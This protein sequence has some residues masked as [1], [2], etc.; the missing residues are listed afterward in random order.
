MTSVIG[1]LLLFPASVALLAFG[2]MWEGAVLSVLWGWFVVPL[3]GLPPLSLPF[4]IGLAL[5]VGLLTAHKTGNESTDPDKKWAPLVTMVA[6]PGAA[7]LVGW[8]VTKFL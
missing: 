8:I 2:V 3:F 4:A 1:I 7:L 6:R 5:V